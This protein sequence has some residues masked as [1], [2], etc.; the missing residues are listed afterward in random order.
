MRTNRRHVALGLAALLVMGALAWVVASALGGKFEAA[1]PVSVTFGRAGQLLSPGGDVKMRGVLVG[2][3]ESIEVTPDGNAR[4]NLSM[5]PSQRIPDNVGASVR[6]KTLFGEKFVELRDGLG[7]ATGFLAPGAQI[8]I[9]RTVD[10]FELESVLQ[11]AL[12]VLEAV[13]PQA[14]S[15][16]L[17][18]LAQGLGG[19]EAEAGRAL[20]NG[21]AALANLNASRAE[22]DRLISGL[23]ESSA[24]FAGAAP[25]LIEA[26]EDLDT[27]NRTI[28]TGRADLEAALAE[29]PV[30]LDTLA[31]IMEARLADLIDLSVLGAD[32]L[33]LLAAHGEDLPP[34]VEALKDFAG[35]WVGSLSVGCEN[36]DG[37]T[38][39]EVHPK[40]AGSTCWQIWQPSA[41]NP[42]VPGAYGPGEAPGTTSASVYRRQLSGIMGLSQG[43]DPGDLAS[44]LFSPLRGLN[45]S[46]IGGIP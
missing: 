4:V 23:D 26:F 42:R 22:L 3:V 32:V 8:Q 39:A 21:V 16:A 33:D 18:A 45:G 9:E 36:R 25:D 31:A 5:D 13:D 20:D 10:P 19:V 44:M 41:E 40:L 1:Y 35:A 37:M 30:W 11:R 7:A 27:F 15:A 17:S 43:E 38:I 24:A 46:I 29:A 6:G 28:L 2:R 12:P 34:T 14:L